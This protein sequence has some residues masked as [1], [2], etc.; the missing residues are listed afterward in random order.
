MQIRTEC[1]RPKILG[2]GRSDSLVED[3]RICA[4]RCQHCV[5]PFLHVACSQERLA[6]QVRQCHV[7]CRPTVRKMMMLS[8]SHISK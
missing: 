3:V 5:A 2:D 8:N 4:T 1:R 6:L 7:A